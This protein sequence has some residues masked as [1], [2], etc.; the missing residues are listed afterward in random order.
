MATR[1]PNFKH[2]FPL[3]ILVSCAVLLLLLSP[4]TEAQE[5]AA[6][7]KIAILVFDSIQLFDFM[8][9][10]DVLRRDNDVYL[11]TEKPVIE[12]YG[13]TIPSVKITPQYTFANA[14]RPDV[15]VIPGGG[16][17]KPGKRGVGTQIEQG[18]KLAAELI[19]RESLPG[20]SIAVAVDG[21]TVWSEGFGFADLDK[22]VLASPK[23]RFRIGS[24]SKLLTAAALARAYEKGLID[25]DAPVQRYVPTFP[26]KEQEI[27]IR[28]LAGHLS[29]IRQY[30]RDEYINRRS[31]S[32]VLKSLNVFQDSPLLFP[33]GTK[34]GYSSYGYDLLGAAIEGATKQNFLSYVQQQVFRP[35]KMK[36]T[37]ADS[38]QKEVPNRTRFYSRDS[39][40]QIVAA[41]ETDLSDR[42]PAGGFLSTVEDLARFGSALLKDGFLKSETRNLMFTS[43]RTAD[44]KET[45][46]GLAW[47]ISKDEKGRRILHHGGDS[48]GARAFMLIYPEQKIVVVMLS[49]LTFAR[50]A[51]QDA[52]KFAERFMR[53]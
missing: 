25:L 47:R 26:K 4:G 24:L 44:G 7:P 29:G 48:V 15:L 5:K 51:E 35:L 9:P 12:T 18:R 17:N 53:N 37:I 11:V 32:T 22:K 39:T 8:G 34:Y 30:S 42:L 6:R 27:T 31:Y 13:G 20:L 46:V 43:Q 41:P 2:L 10:Y 23:T 28:Q 3:S 36:S 33:P 50:F 45:G 19:K 38:A 52:S 1:T 49:N 21:K 40:G 14:P 16:S